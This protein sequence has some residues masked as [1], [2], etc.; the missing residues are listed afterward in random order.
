[1]GLQSHPFLE[2][3]LP[4]LPTFSGAYCPP[5]HCNRRLRQWQRPGQAPPLKKL[6]AVRL[7]VK[8]L[9]VEAPVNEIR[10]AAQG[11][12]QLRDDRFGGPELP[13]SKK[14]DENFAQ[15]HRPPRQGTKRSKIAPTAMPA[16]VS[17][18]GNW[19]RRKSIGQVVDAVTTIKELVGT[20]GKDN[21]LKL[22]EA[23]FAEGEPLRDM[24]TP[25]GFCLQSSCSSFFKNVSVSVRDRCHRRGRSR[26]TP[27]QA[28]GPVSIR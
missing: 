14:P 12:V 23:V 22:V 6:P 7:I 8:E 4:N 3:K 15:W 16:L 2:N 9:G 18:K 26:P 19:Q 25:A 10:K 17:A 24:V 27:D 21:L 20:L 28:R 5:V 1:M 11:E 13:V